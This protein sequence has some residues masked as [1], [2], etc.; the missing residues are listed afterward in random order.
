MWVKEYIIEAESE[1][2]IIIK[3]RAQTPGQAEVKF[4]ITSQD[5][6]MNSPNIIVTVE[7]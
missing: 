5:I 3:L 1:I 2:N 7:K 6:Y 4:S